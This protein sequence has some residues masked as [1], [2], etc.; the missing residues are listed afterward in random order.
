MTKTKNVHSAKA[1]KIDG[2]NEEVYG[3]AEALRGITVESMML[4]A[5]YA[6]EHRHSRQDIRTISMAWERNAMR[7]AQAVARF[8]EWFM[9]V[10]GMPPRATSV[11]DVLTLVLLVGQ[12]KDE[13]DSLFREWRRLSLR[14]W[15]MKE[16]I[17]L[18]RLAKAK[19]VSLKIGRARV[20]LMEP[21]SVLLKVHPEHYLTGSL[22]SEWIDKEVSATLTQLKEAD[23]NG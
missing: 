16:R 11:D 18:R 14:Y 15:Q 19:V 17:E 20:E 13:C 6:Y 8:P 4:M 9:T 22:P 2:L 10:E 21:S 7:M 12:K 23:N 1:M 3:E 5:L